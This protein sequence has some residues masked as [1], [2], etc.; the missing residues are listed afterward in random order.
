MMQIVKITAASV[1]GMLGRTGWGLCLCSETIPWER[2][3]TVRTQQ[4]ELPILSKIKWA[5]WLKGIF[6]MRVP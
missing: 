5:V 6:S 1:K 3:T 2:T 4:R